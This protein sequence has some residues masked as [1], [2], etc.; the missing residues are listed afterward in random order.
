MPL[1]FDP[2]DFILDLHLGTPGLGDKVISDE[3]TIDAT[4]RMPKKA[5]M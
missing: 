3:I 2:N 1:R 4:I 5:P